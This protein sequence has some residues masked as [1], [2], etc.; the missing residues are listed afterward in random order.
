MHQRFSIAHNDLLSLQTGTLHRDNA[1]MNIEH[2][3]EPRRL[4]I[5]ESAAPDNK[6]N[7]VRLAYAAMVDTGGAQHLGARALNEFQ[8]VGVVND[9]CRIGILIEHP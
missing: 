3:I 6:Q 5:I 2:I 9:S 8:I 1:G 7:T 4:A